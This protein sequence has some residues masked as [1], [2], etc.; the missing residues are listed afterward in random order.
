MR[1]LLDSHAL[2]WALGNDPALGPTARKVLADPA[3]G[4]LVSGVSAME[5]MTKY[6]K[7]RLPQAEALARDFKGVLEQLDCTP[8][9][10][11]F[12]HL[13]LAGSLDIPLKDPFD[14]LLIAQAR[15]ERVPIVSN[16]K[17]FDAFG[18]ERIW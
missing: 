5:I 18:V 7:G 16:E 10:V 17:L 12:D 11:G 8:L 14:R 4:K 2:I 13:L 6:R 3:I 1:V 9:H 15:I